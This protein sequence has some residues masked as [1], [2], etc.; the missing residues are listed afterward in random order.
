MHNCNSKKHYIVIFCLIVISVVFS[1]CSST[2][3]GNE[4]S[5][6]NVKSSENNSIS[7]I[8][9]IFYST[10]VL[11][12]GNIINF[13]IDDKELDRFVKFEIVNPKTSQIEKVIDIR[14]FDMRETNMTC[15]NDCFYICGDHIY[16]YNF[17][18]DLLKKINY[19]SDIQIGFDISNSV[20]AISNDLSKMVYNFRIEDD[21]EDKIGI[22]LLDLNSNKETII[23]SLNEPVTDKPCDYNNLH[24]SSDDKTVMFLGQRYLTI[25][26]GR[27]CYGVIDLNNLNIKSDFVKKSYCRFVKDSGY[28]YDKNV[29]FGKTSSGKII[30]FDESGNAETIQ[31][32]NANESQHIGLTDN[33]NMFLSILCNWSD[34]SIEI[35]LYEN[36]KVIKKADI[37][38]KNEEEFNL[39]NVDDICYS[40]KSNKTYYSSI[41]YDGDKYMGNEYFEL[42]MK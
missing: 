19:P 20:F 39:I 37:K 41:V 34:Y 23:Q 17:S 27:D 3:N 13:Y 36:G 21:V 25:N 31:L 26:D 33:E 30:K 12:N 28:V 1:S 16:V 14:S 42:E 5:S 2:Q 11:N 40:S 4:T 22:K 15:L 9:G 38:C 32:E 8:G 18:G 10:R 6:Q 24:F 35:R 7:D 29:D